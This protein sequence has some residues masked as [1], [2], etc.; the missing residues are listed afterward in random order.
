MLH[1]V[2]IEPHTHIQDYFEDT[3]LQVTWE[4]LEAMESEVRSYCRGIPTVFTAAK[5]SYV[6]DQQGNTYI[7]FLAAAG[8]L[9]YGHNDPYIK[10]AIIDYM[11]HD[12]VVQTL[13]FATQAKSNF[14]QRFNSV[15]LGPRKLDYKI[16]FTGPTGT[17]AVEAA[18][19]L[20]RKV[21]KRS[22]IAAF[23]NAFHGVSL[24]SLAL[25]GNKSKR[26]ASGVSLG[27][28]I[29]LPYDGYLGEG[30][31]TLDYARKLFM[32]PSSG[33]EAPAAFIVEV[34]QGEGGLNLA[35]GQW[36]RNLAKLAKDL[37][38]LLIVDD[39]Q[40]GCGRSGTFFS[41]EKMDVVPDLICLSKSI[42]G[43]GLPMA[44]VLI[45]PELDQWLPGEH[46]GTFRGNNLAFIGA[47]AALDY[48]NT[49]KFEEDIAIRTALITESLTELV[50]R[51]FAGMAIIKGRG[52][53]QGIAF[54]DPEVAESMRQ[55]LVAKYLIAET[56]GPHDEVIK[57]MPALNIP[58]EAL[59]EGLHIMHDA[60]KL[61]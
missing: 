58:L 52:M 36:M 41:F 25:T 26:R 1:S 39:I 2:N 15:I 60:A 3:E 59:H 55:K 24:G 49:P 14:L 21:T 46:N 23:T 29:R 34:I 31:D 51:H 22:S 11:M 50:A 5:G 28:V 4:S 8:S 45:K 47:T 20:A 12:G 56:S 32:D 6:Y 16:Q 35:S 13:D 38:S 40:A 9:N 30:V 27:D 17:N 43:Y 19:K 44:I 37:G 48:W 53:F 42:G 61:M 10:A 18:I 54:N 33:I 57:V 7:D